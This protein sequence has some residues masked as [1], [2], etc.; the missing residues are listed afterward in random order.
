[1][2]K[3]RTF[4]AFLTAFA[5]S[6]LFTYI[7]RREMLKKIDVKS[8]PAR[9]HPVIIAAK[10][11]LPGDV[12]E[13][14]SVNIQSWPD[15]IS[16]S[17]TFG[18][19]DDVTGKPVTEE[20]YAG[21]V[22]RKER[23]VPQDGETRIEN[24]IPIGMR[25]VTIT[26]DDTAKLGGLLEAG[27]LV[28]VLVSRRGDA[29][30]SPLSETVLQGVKVLALGEQ[31]GTVARGNS[32]WSTL[33]LLVTPLQAARLGS[34]IDRGKIMLTLRNRTDHTTDPSL[35]VPAS[36]QAVTGNVVKQQANRS[37]SG[38]AIRQDAAFSVELVAGSKHTSES[39]GEV[40]P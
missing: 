23:F 14:S 3:Q 40:K 4:I 1:M 8:M 10:D 11:L 12:V 16:P 28:D 15:T 13:A 34:A 26:A 5:L 20:I 30:L 38:A 25:A 17:E 32:T 27:S 33:T 39:F 6:S 7:L 18:K 37:H 36:L 24:K 9:T 29:N 35:G 22:L 2:N 21:E 31:A 19:L